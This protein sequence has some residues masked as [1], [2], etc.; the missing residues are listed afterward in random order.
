MANGSPSRSNGDRSTRRSAA[1]PAGTLRQLAV[2][3]GQVHR[4]ATEAVT[5]AAQPSGFVDPPAVTEPAELAGWLRAGIAE[6]TAAL[7]PAGLDTPTWHLFDAPM[8]TGVWRRRQAHETLVH[9]IDAE[10]AIGTPTPVDPAFASDGVDEYFGL[11]IP[12][13]VRR[14]R[15]AL[16]SVSLHVH[17]TDT[18]GEWLIRA[19]DGGYVVVR[20]HAKGDAA[21]RGPAGALLM[22]LWGRPTDPFGEVEIV[23]DPAAAA[24]WLAVGGT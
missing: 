17:C 22:K 9:R 7:R 1:V 19:E 3:L 23:G 12:R 18:H 24:A 13:L 14:E 10:R 20:E 2:H 8:T 4:W 11:I 6:L 5:T 21:L 15:T 16:P